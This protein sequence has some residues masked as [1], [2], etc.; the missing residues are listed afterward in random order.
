MVRR[1]SHDPQYDGRANTSKR[2][3]RNRFWTNSGPAPT[4]EPPTAASIDGTT[5]PNVLHTRVTG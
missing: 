1:T 4:S 3:T 2:F 5:P